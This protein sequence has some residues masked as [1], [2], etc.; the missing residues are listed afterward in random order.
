MLVGCPPFVARFSLLA[1]CQPVNPQPNP[2]RVSGGTTGV[3]YVIV[4]FEV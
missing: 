1:S 3:Q 2:A 4:T